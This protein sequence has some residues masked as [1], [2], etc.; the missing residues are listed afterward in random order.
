MKLN[1][2]YTQHLLEVILS[3]CGYF[4][5]GNKANIKKIK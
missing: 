1:S 5:E 3:Q 4:Y 2:E